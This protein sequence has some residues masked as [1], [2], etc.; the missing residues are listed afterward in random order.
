MASMGFNLQNRQRKTK[1]FLHPSPLQFLKVTSVQC[2]RK[3]Y[4]SWP[5]FLPCLSQLAHAHYHNINFW[6]GGVRSAP[7]AQCG[8]YVYS[9]HSRGGGG[10]WG[11]GHC[12]C[13]RTWSA[14]LI[15]GWGHLPRE[16]IQ[17]ECLHTQMWHCSVL[18]P[19]SQPP[20]PCPTS[21]GPISLLEKSMH[22]F[23]ITSHTT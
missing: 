11:G 20:T 2:F 21:P 19:S 3:D 18:W 15:K 17:P 23:P 1:P 8:S 7:L 22:L 13:N 12:C 14:F 6:Q 16:S 9:S 4:T 5:Y 10:Q